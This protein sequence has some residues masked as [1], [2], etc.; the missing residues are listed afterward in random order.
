MVKMVKM[1]KKYFAFLV[2]AIVCVSFVSAADTEID[3]KTVPNYEVQLSV[4]EAGS[5]AFA[6]IGRSKAI[7]DQYGDASFTFSI[8][9]SKYN[10]AIFIKKDGENVVDPTRL[11][12]LI[13]GEKQN[14]TILPAWATA[15][16]TPSATEN[17]SVENS[18]LTNQTLENQTLETAA[19]KD[20]VAGNG[21]NGN[22]IS[23]TGLFIFEKGKQ[24]FS[25]NITY[26][27]IAILAVGV[28]AFVI[29]RK[30]TWPKALREIK[31]K[32]L[33]ELNA[34]REEEK[35]KGNKL[36]EAEEKLKEAQQEVNRLKNK[37]R[38]KELEER[39]EEERKELEKL[40]EG[41][42]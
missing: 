12:N 28:F 17:L 27:I 42:D 16:P 13:S 7:S 19:K 29:R 40:K 36:K 8:N 10:L 9:K 20:L 30:F 33:S 32:K 5:V 4:S 15:I 38:V 39:I 34:E 37:T 22:F 26:Y 23:S 11:T 18:S 2:L 3:V 35:R 24:I 1:V 14:F 6:E 21:S 41:E 31:V 25:S